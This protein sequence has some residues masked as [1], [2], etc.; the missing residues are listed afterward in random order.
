MVALPLPRRNTTAYNGVS[1]LMP[2]WSE[3]AAI[4]VITE[5]A[6]R[7]RERS[8]KEYAKIVVAKK[9]LGLIN[10]PNITGCIDMAS[11]EG[12]NL[13]FAERYKNIISGRNTATTDEIE[14][15]EKNE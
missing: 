15:L 9:N 2:K 7:E 13:N 8:I 1:K 6:N 11:N 10:E 3:A 12:K 14:S 4:K 5:D